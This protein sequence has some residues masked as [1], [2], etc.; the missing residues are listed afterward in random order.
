M[1]M[2]F[3]L[4]NLGTHQPVCELE[5]DSELLNPEAGIVNP[6]TFRLS[7]FRNGNLYTLIP[8]EE[9]HTTVV[10]KNV[11]RIYKNITEAP[12][13]LLSSAIA[14]TDALIEAVGLMF[15]TIEYNLVTEPKDM[16]RLINP[17]ID[18]PPPK[19][20]KYKIFDILLD[21]E[22]AVKNEP[23]IESENI[24]PHEHMADGSCCKE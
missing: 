7:A 8:I 12:A 17:H 3:V 4:M 20:V 13:V 1:K 2:H 19:T 9:S 18:Q 5:M 16:D 15:N 14:R 11:K 24:G 10:L 23:T 21:E 22:T 6:D